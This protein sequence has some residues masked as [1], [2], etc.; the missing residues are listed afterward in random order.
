MASVSVDTGNWTLE[1]ATQIYTKQII[2]SKDNKP[3]RNKWYYHTKY[4][5]TCLAHILKFNVH[6][7]TKYNVISYL[8][9]LI[10]LPVLQWESQILLHDYV[11]FCRSVC[12]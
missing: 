6:V 2:L 1:C 12:L 5:W 10:P 11:L 7:K 3:F 8:Q 9:V 4:H